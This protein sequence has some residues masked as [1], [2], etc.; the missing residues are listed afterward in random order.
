M[1]FNR[2]YFKDAR[3]DRLLE[4]APY[5]SVWCKTNAAVARRDLTGIDILPIV[6]FTFLKGVARESPR[7][8]RRAGF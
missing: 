2:G 1:N 6:D 4:D 3:V 7:D 8:A 5:I